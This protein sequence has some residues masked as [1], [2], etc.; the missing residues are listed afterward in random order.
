MD[1]DDKVGV[2]ERGWREG[3][4]DGWTDGRVGR[5]GVVRVD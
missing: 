3:S 1:V 5:C 2:S 4:G